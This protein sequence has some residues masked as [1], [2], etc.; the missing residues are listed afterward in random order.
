LFG[1]SGI[2]APLVVGFPTFPGVFGDVALISQALSLIG[3]SLARLLA[4]LAFIGHPVAGVGGPVALLGG[5]LLGGVRGHTS[6]FAP[7]TS[8]L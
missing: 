6:T 7:G 2:G 4:D 5:R 1:N 3:Q 8:D